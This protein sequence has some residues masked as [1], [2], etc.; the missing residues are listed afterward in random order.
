MH[1]DL[2]K[3]RYISI[4]L[5]SLNVSK[6]R[7]STLWSVHGTC[8]FLT[9]SVLRPLYNLYDWTIYEADTFL[10]NIKTMWWIKACNHSFPIFGVI[11]YCVYI[12]MLLKCN[13]I[14]MILR[15]MHC[16]ICWWNNIY[17]KMHWPNADLNI[18]SHFKPWYEAKPP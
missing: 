7:K 11:R 4:T 13:L 8:Y 2:K 17:T 1:M 14:F 10:A 15:P 16:C 12:I 5:I 3:N 18:R 9:G 6:K